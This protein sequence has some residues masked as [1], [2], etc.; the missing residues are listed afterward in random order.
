MDKMIRTINKYAVFIHMVL[1]ALLALSF[2]FGQKSSDF[3]HMSDD[4][5]KIQIDV[6]ELR[7]MF[8]DHVRGK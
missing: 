1:T 7:T 3:R 8:F 4:I 2:Y 5:G 6:K